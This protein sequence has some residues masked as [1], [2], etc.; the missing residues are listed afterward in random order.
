MPFTGPNYTIPA[1]TLAPAVVGTPISAADW[2]AFITDLETALSDTLRANTQAFTGQVEF[3]PTAPAG[4]PAVTFTTDLDTGIFQKAGNELGLATGGTER[5]LITDTL[6]TVTDNLAVTGTVAA[7]SNITTG[8]NLGVVGSA[9]IDTNLNVDGTLVVDGVSTL[10]GRVTLGAG[11]AGILPTDLPAGNV[12]AVVGNEF[13]VSPAPITGDTNYHDILAPAGVVTVAASRAVLLS[14]GPGLENAGSGYEV[15][16]LYGGSTVAGLL[17]IVRAAG[18]G[19]AAW[20][21]VATITTGW[22][23]GTGALAERST[24]TT[25]DVPG[26]GDFKYKLTGKVTNA[27]GRM[28][29]V[30]IRFQVVTL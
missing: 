10:T 29:I 23:V 24:F 22:A 11:V 26:A 15:T 20:T 9:D 16:L 4:A 5:V 25:I 19:Y 8:G 2:N 21:E 18:P 14:V 17:Q 27:S 30:N 1:G 28:D 6:V 13:G 7:T 12:P 3:D